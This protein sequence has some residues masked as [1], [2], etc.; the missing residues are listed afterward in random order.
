MVAY[1]VVKYLNW[2]LTYAADSLS[3]AGFNIMINEQACLICLPLE[4]VIATKD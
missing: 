4:I 3:K 1:Q 2:R